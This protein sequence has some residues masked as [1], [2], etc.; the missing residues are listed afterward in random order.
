MNRA[1]R[2]I[3]AAAAVAAAVALL[4]VAGCASGLRSGA[5]P[6]VTYALRAAPV[7]GSAKLLDVAVRVDRA[8]P[9]PGFAS[10]RILVVREDRRLDH[11]SGSRWP[12]MLPDVVTALAIETLR[13]SAA[14]TAVHDQRAPFTSDYLLLITIRHFEADASGG[15]APQVRV[16]LECTLGRRDDRVVIATFT[17][18]GGAS[19]SANRMSAVIAAYEAATQ[20]ALAVLSTRTLEALTLD[21]STN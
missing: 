18:A 5:E 4:A 11:Y 1:A 10:E 2:A 14:L 6:T 9:A 17:A 3:R 7:A 13:G 16:A 8:V 15:G 21:T 12:E 20:Q 19:A